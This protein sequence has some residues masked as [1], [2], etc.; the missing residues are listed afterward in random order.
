LKSS[1]LLLFW[2]WTTATSA[3]IFKIKINCR[4]I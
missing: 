1:A 2:I 4:G 3:C